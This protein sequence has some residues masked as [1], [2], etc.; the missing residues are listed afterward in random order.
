MI[1]GDEIQGDLGKVI[2]QVFQPIK[3][4]R[5]R[6]RMRA[7]RPPKVEDVSIQHEHIHFSQV[8]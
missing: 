3:G 8:S 7:T 1:P 4:L 2:L 6:N 5:D